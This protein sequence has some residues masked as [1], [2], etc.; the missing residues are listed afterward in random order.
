MN[1]LNLLKLNRLKD[2]IP[3]KSLIPVQEKSTFT[4]INRPGLV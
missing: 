2:L 4:G 1:N 3:I